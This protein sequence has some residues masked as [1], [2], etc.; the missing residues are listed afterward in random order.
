MTGRVPQSSLQMEKL[1][2]EL[3][4]EGPAPRPACLDQAAALPAHKDPMKAAGE[5]EDEER[6]LRLPAASRPPLLCLFEV[7]LPEGLGAGEEGCVC[8]RA[9]VPLCFPTL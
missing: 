2:Q 3:V 4:L 8:E 9:H 1:R 7:R 6:K 5:E